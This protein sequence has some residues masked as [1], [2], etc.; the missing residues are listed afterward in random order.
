MRID[1]STSEEMLV[2]VNVPRGLP[3]GATIQSMVSKVNNG[4]EIKSMLHK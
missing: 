4:L 2:K 1:D 3:A